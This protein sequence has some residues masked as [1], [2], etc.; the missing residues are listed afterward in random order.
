LVQ[1]IRIIRLKQLECIDNADRCQED[2]CKKENASKRIVRFLT[3][4][5]MGKIKVTQIRSIIDR[6]KDQKATIEA[7]V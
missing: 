1:V 4:D 5:I 2:G 3:E 7:W 6:P